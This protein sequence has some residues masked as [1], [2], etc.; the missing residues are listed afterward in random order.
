[1]EAKLKQLGEVAVICISGPLVIEQTQSFRDACSKH[2]FG[3]KVIFNLENANFVGS[4]GIHSFVEALRI[5]STKS[6][7]GMKLVGLKTE[8]RRIFGNVEIQGME[9]CETEILA[10]AS[11]ARGPIPAPAQ[12]IVAPVAA[13]SISD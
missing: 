1:M 7:Q 8:F 2:F 5:V 12:F 4:T 9:I 3:Q 13:E 11:F 10:L 6:T